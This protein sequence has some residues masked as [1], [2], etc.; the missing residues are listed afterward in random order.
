MF[1]AL[2]L[3]KLPT[4]NRVLCT[5]KDFFNKKSTNLINT[6]AYADKCVDESNKPSL[7]LHEIE[8]RILIQDDHVTSSHTCARIAITRDQYCFYHYKLGE[9]AG[10]CISRCKFAEDQGNEHSAARM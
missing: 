10:K 9:K 1:T 7:P 4:Y 8:N 3:S 2:I 6:A 5:A